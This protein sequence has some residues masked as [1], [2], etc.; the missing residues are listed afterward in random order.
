LHDPDREGIRRRAGAADVD[1]GAQRQQRI[2]GDFSDPPLAR[3][4]DSIC[5]K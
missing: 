3:A 1:E 2:G 4:C 5:A